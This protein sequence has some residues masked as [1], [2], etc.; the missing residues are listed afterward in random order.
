MIIAKFT[1]GEGVEDGIGAVC[2]ALTATRQYRV[3]VNGGTL[4]NG[5]DDAVFDDLY[6][7]K[8]LA[9]SVCSAL[10]DELDV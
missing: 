8:D 2:I 10:L 5:N 1:V 4:P 6:D 7:A 9:F 3:F